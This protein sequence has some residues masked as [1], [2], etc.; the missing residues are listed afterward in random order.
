MNIIAVAKVR[1][2]LPLLRRGEVV[3]H[4]DVVHA[5]LI[6][7]PDEVRAY[8]AGTAGDYNHAFSPKQAYGTSL[9]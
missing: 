1:Q 3:H 9:A 7:P 2:V 6:E 5:V 4:E 8:K